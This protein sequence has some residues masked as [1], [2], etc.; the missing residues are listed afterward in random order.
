MEVGSKM[1]SLGRVGLKVC[2]EYSA[3]QRYNEL[4][5]VTYKDSSYVAKEENINIPP[6]NSQYWMVLAQALDLKV[7]SVEAKHIK[8]GAVEADKIA[9]NAVTADKLQVG[10]FTNYVKDPSFER[11]ALINPPD[12]WGISQQYVRSGTKSLKIW[13]GAK[14]YTDINLMDEWFW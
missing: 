6:T 12:G 10:D 3:S 1:Y 5:V 9:A 13:A 14:A 7:N 8:A 2:G 11:F 4:D